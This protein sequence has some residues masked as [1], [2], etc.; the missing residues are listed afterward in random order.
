M[1]DYDEV[2][3]IPDRTLCQFLRNLKQDFLNKRQYLKFIK[4]TSKFIQICKCSQKICHS[5]CATAHVL[6]NQRIYCIDCFHYFRLY[7]R[8]ER[9]FSTFYTSRVIRMLVLFIFNAV[10]IYGVYELDRY[11]KV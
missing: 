9:I 4:I 11:L 6:R 10:I 1:V 5:Y 7:V 3:R 2:L 8:S